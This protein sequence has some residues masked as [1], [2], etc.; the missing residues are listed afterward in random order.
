MDDVTVTVT[1]DEAGV[2]VSPTTL[3]I[4]E[5]STA[6]YTVV[7]TSESTDNVTITV[8]GH[9]N[10]DATVSP[11][12]LIFTSTN[13]GMPRTVSVTAALVLQRQ[14]RGMWDDARMAARR[15]AWERL[16]RSLL[17]CV[18]SSHRS[19]SAGPNRSRGSI[20]RT[21]RYTCSLRTFV[22]GT[23]EQALIALPKLW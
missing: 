3:T 6:T 11:S 4:S 21:T 7:L 19:N 15:L 12:T 8:S 18:S 2:T 14:F 23:P 1:D 10:T 22:S 9:A 20:S 16:A 17:S 13:R 5:G